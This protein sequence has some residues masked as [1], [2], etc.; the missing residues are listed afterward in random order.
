M[1]VGGVRLG[2]LAAGEH[3]AGYLPLEEHL[4]ILRLGG[5]S[6]SGAQD[7][8]E[9]PLRERPADDLRECREDRVLQLRQ[10]EPDHARASHAQVRRP[11]VA[12]DVERREHGG[13][14]RVGDARLAVEDAADRC[15]ADAG[16]LRDVC[17]I[18][19]HVA[20]IGQAAA[21]LAVSARQGGAA[22]IRRRRLS[23]EGTM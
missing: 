19:R 8:V 12:D 4:D 20:T 21:S 13:T 5:A 17:K 3:H 9:P 2:V 23:V 16:L 11:F 14:G 15:L 10:H 18:S 6:G 1:L 22:P 7:R